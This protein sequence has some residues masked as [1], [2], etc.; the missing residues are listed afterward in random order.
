MTKTHKHVLLGGSLL[1]IV[2][3]LL[4]LDWNLLRGPIERRVLAATGRELHIRGDLDVDLGWHP[5]VTVHDLHFANAAWAKQPTMAHIGRLQLQFALGSLWSGPLRIE[6][7]SL[8]HAQ[9]RLE[10]N[11]RGQGNWQLR[12][13]GD[14]SPSPLLERLEIEHGRL[15]W[16]EKQQKT[17]LELRVQSQRRDG[18]DWLQIDGQGQY[19]GLPARIDGALGAVRS[20][21]DLQQNWPVDIRLAAGDTRLAARGVIYNV[22]QLQGL[23]AQF[24]LSG[25]NLADLYR[26]THIPLPPTAAYKL[27]GRLRHKAGQWQ[28]SGFSGSVGRSDLNGD[29]LVDRRLSRQF[30]RARLHS[31]RLD[32]ADL[33]GFIGARNEQGKPVQPRAGR[34]LPDEEFNLEKLQAADM[35]I[36]YRAQHLLTERWPLQDLRAQLL[37]RNGRLQLTPLSFAIAGGELAM[38]LDMDAA[39]KPMRT[40]AQLR[41]RRLQLDKLLQGLR[42]ERASTGLLGGQARLKVSGNS[43]AQMLASANGQVGLIMRGGSVSILAMRL[44]NLDV[45]NALLVLLRGDRQVPVHCLVGDFKAREGVFTAQTLVLDSDKHVI[46]GS[47]TIDLRRERLDLQLRADAKDVSL[48]A[49]R[50]PIRLQG[51]LASPEASPDLRQAAGRTAAAIVLGSIAGPLALLPLIETGNAED[52][53]CNRLIERSRARARAEP[54]PAD[55]SRAKTPPATHR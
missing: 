3:G 20:R 4:W 8:Q 55:S 31:R 37:L 6:R 22:L 5:Q 28:L 25:A 39:A 48:A 24:S 53:Q 12:D 10:R 46:F 38:Q 41:L 14:Q 15:F 32:L 45:A 36:H 23:E 35:D 49:L 16:Q 27:S 44:A 7:L 1:L 11:A 42:L 26:L 13:S 40:Q 21:A 50:G 29:F 43:V 47:G 17:K 54:P 9:L 30:I 33:S 19:R 2:F 18:R 52:Q 34:V 51:T